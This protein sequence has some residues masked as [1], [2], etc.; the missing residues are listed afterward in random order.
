MLH[1]ADLETYPY[2]VLEVPLLLE[3]G[4]RDLVNRVLV[5]DAP[6]RLQVDRVVTRDQLHPE[7][8]ET[9]IKTQI[10]AEARI[11]QADDVLENSG[12][13]GDLEEQVERLHQ[14][15]LGMALTQD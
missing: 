6:L 14:N 15:Y 1:Q 8:V 2:V 5:I 13:L 4:Y 3:A 9:I 7:Q 10:D 12:N 11:Q